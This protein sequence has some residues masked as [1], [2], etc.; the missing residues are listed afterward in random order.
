MANTFLLK[1]ITPDREVYNGEIEKITLK[2]ADGEFQVLANHADMISSTIPHIAKFIDD[3]GVEHEIFISKALT[4]VSNNEMIIGSDAAEFEEDIDEAR[5]EQAR[6]RAES[7]LRE[8]GL[9][10]KERAEA[11]LLRAKQR[12]LL[13]KSKNK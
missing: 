6:E 3:K 5:A 13:K 7:R 1:I 8:A 2:T 11:A 4:Q 9:Y 10:N 12:L